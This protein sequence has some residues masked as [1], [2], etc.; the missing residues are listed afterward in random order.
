MDGK[1]GV[2][3]IYMQPRLQDLM[4]NSSAEGACTSSCF[5]LVGFGG[6]KTRCRGQHRDRDFIVSLSAL[7]EGAL[8]WA[9]NHVHAFYET[10][11]PSKYQYLNSHLG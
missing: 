6:G 3:T 9:R 2:D 4:P 11:L 1:K 5:R 8:S 7:D 10:C